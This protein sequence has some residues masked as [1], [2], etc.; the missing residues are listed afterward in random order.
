MANAHDSTSMEIS[1]AAAAII[2]STAKEVAEQQSMNEALEAQIQDGVQELLRVSGTR[3]PCLNKSCLLYRITC[4]LSACTHVQ[5]TAP[6]DTERTAPHPQ[7]AAG[8][9]ASRASQAVA[10]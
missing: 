2:A 3:P 10:A 1:P 5:L 6:A 8:A 4:I 7:L 9:C